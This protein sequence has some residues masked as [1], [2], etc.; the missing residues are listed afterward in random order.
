MKTAWTFSRATFRTGNRPRSSPSSKPR[1]WREK[2]PNAPA[3]FP[4]STTATGAL[5][6]NQVRLFGI[7]C[8][9]TVRGQPHVANLDTALHL[10]RM[11]QEAI[12]NAVKHGHAR[13]VE[14]VVEEFPDAI[15]IAVCDDSQGFVPDF[16]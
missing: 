14:I 8:K 1:S 7:V 4:R 3:P 2:S 9:T 5:A 11:I 15:R 16:A 10:Y 6:E 12:H 13:E